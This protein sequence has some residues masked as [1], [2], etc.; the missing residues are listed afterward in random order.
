MDMTWDL[1]SRQSPESQPQFVRLEPGPER[2]FV[3]REREM[4]LVQ[5]KVAAGCQGRAMRLVVTCFWGAFGIGK[6]WLLLELERRHKRQEPQALGSHPTVVARL[7]LNQEILP[8]LWHDD[9]LDREWLIRELWKQLAAQIGVEM[10]DLGRV[11]ADEWAAAFVRQATAWAA[12]WATPVIM[13]DTVDDLV[14]RDE[15]TFFW[16]E[17]HL[18]EPLA[19]TDRVL[20][21]LT[22]RGELRRWRRF[23]VRR[24]VDSYRL[25]SFDAE[26]AGREVKAAAEVSQKLFRH[27]FGHPLATERLGTAL[28]KHGVNLQKAATIEQ[29]IEPSLVQQVLERVIKEALSE[30]PELPQSFARYASVLR[31]VSPEPLRFL[32]QDVDPASAGR[33]DAYYLDLIAELQGHHLLYWDS[34]ENSYE[35]D[36]MLR[37]LLG[38]FLELAEPERF[39]AA[40]LAALAFHRQHLEQFPQ[41]LARYVPELAYHQAMLDRCQPS[42]AQLPAFQEWWTQFLAEKAPTFPEPWEE[43][44]KALAKDRELQDILPAADYERLRRET[45]ERAARAAK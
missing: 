12:Q 35:F 25:T 18:V 37:R 41:Y 9:Q 32:A 43:L 44:I 10:P 28:E 5:D 4:V 16:L 17:Q 27:A 38:H 22:S 31:W 7:D 40:H 13:L 19:L 33:G 34:D 6:S 11:S 3:N 30:V 14:R 39:R 26:T 45:Q 1:P 36:P 15:P 23:Q 42:E 20:F 29:G 2:P 24:R 21:I 8:A